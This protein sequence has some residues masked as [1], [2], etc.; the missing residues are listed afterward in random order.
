MHR[1]WR[2]EHASWEDYRNMAWECRDVIRK[3]KAQLELNLAR[4]T[5]NNKKSFYRYIKQQRKIK[6]FVYL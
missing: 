3:A 4:N 6:E 5:E 2:Q 1:Q